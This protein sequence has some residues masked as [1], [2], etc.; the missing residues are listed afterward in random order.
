MLTAAVSCLPDPTDAVQACDCFVGFLDEEGSQALAHQ[1][2]MSS[3]AQVCYARDLY[4]KCHG[5]ACLFG[6]LHNVQMFLMVWV[7]PAEQVAPLHALPCFA[8]LTI[9]SNWNW[10]IANSWRLS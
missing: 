7:R 10:L 5:A 9:Y 8:M 3:K 4:L 2:D 6:K 1:L